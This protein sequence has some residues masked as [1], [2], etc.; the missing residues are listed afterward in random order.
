MQT[1]R[2]YPYVI[3]LHG[4]EGQGQPAYTGDHWLDLGV[5]DALDRGITLGHLPPMVLVL[6]DGNRIHAQNTFGPGEGYEAVIVDEL[7][8]TL[9]DPNSGYC[10]WTAREGRAIG[11]ISRGGFWA[12]EIAFRHPEI[13][14]AVGGHSAYFDSSAP[15]AYNPLFLAENTPAEYLGSLRIYLDHGADDYVQPLVGPFSDALEA[16]QI[17][18]DYVVNITG[19]HSDEYWG[20][21]LTEYLA[22]YG[23]RWPDDAYQ[24]PSCLEPVGD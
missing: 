23:E 19:T 12:F 9:E 3:L 14:S 11:G 1:Q 24:L 5:A 4:L 22:F 21:H 10:L 18:H 2:R 20:N 6:P 17:A 7:I 8:P 15:D 16:R 13:F